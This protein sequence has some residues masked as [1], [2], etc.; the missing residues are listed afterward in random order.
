M[1]TTCIWT[2]CIERSE[3]DEKDHSFVI[4][5][6]LLEVGSPFHWLVANQESFYSIEFLSGLSSSRYK[7]IIFIGLYQ[8]YPIWFGKG[9][10]SLK[11]LE[12]HFDTSHCSLGVLGPAGPAA[13]KRSFSWQLSCLGFFL[14][15]H[16][17]WVWSISWRLFKT[18]S[19]QWNELKC[20][21]QLKISRQRSQ[22]QISQIC[23][24]HENQHL[25]VFE[26][27]NNLLTKLTSA[28]T[29][30]NCVKPKSILFPH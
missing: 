23:D 18:S 28:S 9:Y 20:D 7:Q 4:Y 27:S 21:K 6:V 30:S 10:I 14:F 13:S 3:W 11:S 12:G 2:P 24:T 5:F 19:T 26:N 25:L 17:N 8:W 16:E 29:H 15:C 1:Y 22:V